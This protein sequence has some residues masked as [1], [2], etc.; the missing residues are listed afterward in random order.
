MKSFF[1]GIIIT[2]FIWALIIYFYLLRVD[3][4]STKYQINNNNNNII[5]ELIANRLPQ[6][7]RLISRLNNNYN[8][9]NSL[10]L[11]RKFKDNQQNSETNLINDNPIDDNVKTR[12]EKNEL[13]LKNGLQ[14]M[15]SSSL[16]KLGMINTAEDK[17][18]KDI[19]YKKHAFNVLISNRIGLRRQIPDTRNGLCK[20]SL[21]L[22]PI[23]DLP[24]ASVII[25]FYNEAFSALLRTVYSVIDRTNDKLLNE[26]ILVDDFSDDGIYH[27][28]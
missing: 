3:F 24:M 18:I 28:F 26:I 14:L 2:S 17:Q 16:I 9:I 1:L 21:S 12:E 27:L 4:N 19:G 20:T 10:K 23:S 7:H 13:Q 8:N 25:C 5:N 22:T 11:L 15:G 6:R